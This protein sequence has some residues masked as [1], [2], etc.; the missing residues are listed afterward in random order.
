MLPASTDRKTSHGLRVQDMMPCI[1]LFTAC[2]IVSLLS[3]CSIEGTGPQSP[4]SAAIPATHKIT[5]EHFVADSTDHLDSGLLR[6]CKYVG[7]ATPAPTI[8][9]SWCT[10]PKAI[11]QKNGHSVPILCNRD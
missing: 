8:S 3:A 1:L 10:V 7:S 11:H 4:V 5:V 2:V 9:Q 6:L